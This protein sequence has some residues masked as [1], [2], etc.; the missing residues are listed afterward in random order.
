MEVKV[1][2]A[3]NGLKDMNKEDGVKAEKV[4]KTVMQVMSK[5]FTE[6][7]RFNSVLGK[8][9]VQMGLMAVKY[10]DKSMY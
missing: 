1:K 4:I 6:A 2:N 5:A 7:M 8:E 9:T 10:V 3:I